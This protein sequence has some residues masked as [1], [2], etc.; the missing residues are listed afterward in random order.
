MSR[1]AFNKDKTAQNASFKEPDASSAIGSLF[2][3]VEELSAVPVPDDGMDGEYSPDN[4][5]ITKPA[6]KKGELIGSWIVAL[7]ILIFGICLFM[8]PGF[9]YRM[10][11]DLSVLALLAYGIINLVIFLLYGKHGRSKIVYGLMALAFG[12]V[13]MFNRLLPEWIIRVVFGLYCFGVGS[14]MFI[15][16]LISRRDGNP[17]KV[18]LVLFSVAYLIL[19]I[20][21]LGTRMVTTTILIEIF[22]IYFCML[23][24]RFTIDL[25]ERSNQEYHWKRSLHISLPTLLATLMPDFVLSKISQV[26]SSGNDYPLQ[27][28]KRKEPVKL[29]AMV[30]IGPEGFQKVGHFTFSWKGIVYS[31][32]NYDTDSERFFSLIGDGVFFTVPSELYL[33]NIVK[34]ENNTI[35]EYSI[36]TTPEQDEQIEQALAELKSRSYRWYSKLER[37]AFTG[38]GELESDYPSRLHYRTGAK[39]YKIRNGCFK[40]YWVAGENCVQFADVILGTIGADVLSLRGIVTPGAY[41]DYLDS[42]YLKDNSPII[43]RRIFSAA[44]KREGI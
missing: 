2:D 32:G 5:V 35:F 16:I 36:Q 18:S 22:G 34:Y 19:G 29:K 6:L 13:L 17:V 30:H 8:A 31:Y 25:L 11:L 23:G 33:P 9:M 40:T 24:I 28:Y 42:E 38:L 12:I 4:D 21:L 1:P 37:T 20:V 7:G 15:Q 43:E 27:A 3:P 41:F 14:A 26:T 10:I 44:A 39:F